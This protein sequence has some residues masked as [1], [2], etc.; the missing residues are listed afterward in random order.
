M[1][2]LAGLSLRRQRIPRLCR[3][4]L[5]LASSKHMPAGAS[6]WPQ[7]VGWLEVVA[8]LAGPAGGGGGV[9]FG[10][11]VGEDGDGGGGGDGVAV[12]ACFRAVVVPGEGGGGER[13]VGWGDGGGGGGDGVPASRPP[14]GEGGGEGAAG[15]IG[16]CRQVGLQE[17]V[18]DRR[19]GHPSMHRVAQN[20]AIR[21]WAGAQ[22]SPS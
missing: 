13:G 4:L 6:P 5:C 11:G 17:D 14:A 16:T 18:V 22:A 19:A 7:G 8:C 20:R 12:S 9:G 21:R 10:G 2:P 3:A 15:V 1:L